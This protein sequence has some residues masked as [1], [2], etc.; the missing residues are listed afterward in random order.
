MGQTK[1]AWL[2]ACF[3]KRNE[4][5]CVSICYFGRR[6][7]GRFSLLAG[8]L[9][10]LRGKLTTHAVAAVLYFVVQRYIHG[11]TKQPEFI[12]LISKKKTESSNLLFSLQQ[13]WSQ[14]RHL[15]GTTFAVKLTLCHGQITFKKIVPS[16]LFSGRGCRSRVASKWFSS[17]C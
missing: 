12:P 14:R 16:S 7:R 10:L 3:S 13:N 9:M 17:Q 6:K 8:S 2:A 15:V 4:F 1:C 5:H 11:K